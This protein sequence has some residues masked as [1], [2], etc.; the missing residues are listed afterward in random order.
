MEYLV[1]TV[2][3]F[4]CLSSMGYIAYFLAQK[5]YLHKAGYYLLLAGFVFHIAS[6]IYD[7]ALS[8]LMPA[9]NL[10]ETL[11][12]AGCATAGVFLILSYKFRLKILGGFAAPLSTII[13]IFAAT[14][15]NKPIPADSALNSIWLPIHVIAIFIGEAAFA[16]A[17]CIGVFYLVQERSI[18]RKSHGFFF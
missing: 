7:F 10:Y 15:Q 17:C 18:K 16:M 8:G 3:L 13:M 11:S 4:Y 6:I 12:V 14:I 9:R 2:I 1:L 5:E